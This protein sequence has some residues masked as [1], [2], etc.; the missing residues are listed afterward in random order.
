MQKFPQGSTSSTNG[1]TI[2]GNGN[3]T[4]LN[5]L[6]GPH[7][8]CADVAG[9]IYVT[10]ENNTRILM[11][12]PNV[13]P[14]VDSTVVAGGHGYGSASNQLAH[15]KDLCVDWHG[16]IYIG[17]VSNYRVQMWRP[18]GWIDTTFIPSGPGNY[19]AEITFPG[20]CVQTATAFNLGATLTPS[21]NI[22]INS[23]SVCPR[24]AAIFKATPI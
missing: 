2:I 14:G 1:I 12:P 19:I 23:N 18:N 22:S 3:G 13:I 16:N 17:D 10:D 24:A 4:P 7:S 15:P 5:Q 11:F 9:N 6:S 21:V 20:G 8:I